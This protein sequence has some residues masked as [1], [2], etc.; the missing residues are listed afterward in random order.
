[1]IRTFIKH[2]LMQIIIGL[3][4]LLG[5]ASCYFEETCTPFALRMLQEK[6]LSEAFLAIV[7]RIISCSPLSAIVCRKKIM[8]AAC[9]VGITSV[10]FVASFSTV[11]YVASSCDIEMIRRAAIIQAFLQEV[12]TT[13]GSATKGTAK[14]DHNHNGYFG[15]QLLDDS[16]VLSVSVDNNKNALCLT[17]L[18]P[19]AFNTSALAD[20]IAT[21]FKASSVKKI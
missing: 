5:P 21:Y 15:T 11:S 4:P 13:V 20:L 16:G 19:E 7:S 12:A 2:M 1:M 3:R 6:S 8:T 18:R 9:L 10:Q 14:I 17:V